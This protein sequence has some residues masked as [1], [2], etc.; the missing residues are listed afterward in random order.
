MIVVD[1]S[2][3]VKWILPEPFS[4]EA[5]R[6]LGAHV[7]RIAPEHVLVEVGQVL[8]R[9]VRTRA[10]PLE[11]AREAVSALPQLVQVL[12][13]HRLATYALEAAVRVGCTNYDALYI[14]AAER[15]DAVFVT[16]DNA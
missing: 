10:I 16:A 13:T 6:L 15:W 3:A 9:A 1:A 11:R 7:V 4:E 2:V 8:R 12:P 14:A 5:E